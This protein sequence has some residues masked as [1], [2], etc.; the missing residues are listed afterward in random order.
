[1]NSPS[2]HASVYEALACKCSALGDKQR[3]ALHRFLGALQSHATI[4]KKQFTIKQI[5][6][7]LNNAAD[8]ARED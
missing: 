3:Y 1:M 4:G 7:M 5:V 6:T 8:N 2:T